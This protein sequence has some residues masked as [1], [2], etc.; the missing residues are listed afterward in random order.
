MLI[1]STR[2]SIHNQDFFLEICNILENDLIQEVVENSPAAQAGMIA[3]SDYIIG[4]DTILQDVFFFIS[5]IVSP[6]LTYC[7]HLNLCF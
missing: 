6:L 1:R 4:A 2:N 5:F 3:G 7:S